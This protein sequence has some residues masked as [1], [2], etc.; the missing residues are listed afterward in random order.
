VDSADWR[1]R[2]DRELCHDGW[3][4]RTGQDGDCPCGRMGAQIEALGAFWVLTL[5]MLAAHC[6]L[7]LLLLERY[8]RRDG[9]STS[10]IY[11]T[12]LRIPRSQHV[13]RQ[14]VKD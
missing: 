12:R 11:Q 7:L 5:L 10:S 9:L 14:S 8:T 1:G 13:L 4:V 3:I 2:L 6:T